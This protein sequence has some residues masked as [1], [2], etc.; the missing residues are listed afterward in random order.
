M[1]A[2]EGHTPQ[3]H[4][5]EAGVAHEGQEPQLAAEAAEAQGVHH[6]TDGPWGHEWLGGRG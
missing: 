3:E 4:G 5:E 1:N 6:L 2:E